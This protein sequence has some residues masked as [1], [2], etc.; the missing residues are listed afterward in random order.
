MRILNFG[1]ELKGRYRRDDEYMEKWG[2][3]IPN[4]CSML[5]IL[6]YLRRDFGFMFY[7]M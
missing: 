7:G 5:E 4:C 2:Q 6:A 3:Y 1:E